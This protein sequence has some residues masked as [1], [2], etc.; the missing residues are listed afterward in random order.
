MFAKNAETKNIY[1]KCFQKIFQDKQKKYFKSKGE[2]DYEDN[3]QNK[4]QHHTCR[5]SNKG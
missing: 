5:K 3:N 1:K 2:I 4:Q